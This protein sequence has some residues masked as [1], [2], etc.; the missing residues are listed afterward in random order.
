MTEFPLR[1]TEENPSE[2][3]IKEVLLKCRKIAVVGLSPKEYRDSHR[4]AK[5]LIEKGYDI[6]PVN[7]GRNQ[8]LGRP[9]YRTLKDIPLKV[10][11]V[12]IFLSPSRVPPVVDQ[13]IEI[14]VPVLWM[15][16]GV[17][18]ERAA[19]KARKAGITVIVEKCAKQEHERIR[20]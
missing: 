10:D 2:E 7:P 11:M 1:Q 12:D 15:Q 6:V 8:I 18:H 16:L 17:F 13:A 19:Q 9:C 20:L 3:T 5:Y 4:V 14:G